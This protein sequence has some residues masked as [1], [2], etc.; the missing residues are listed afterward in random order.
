[1][2]RGPLGLFLCQCKY[3]PGI[4][5]ECGLLGSKLVDFPIE[6]NHKLPLVVGTDLD[7]LSRYRRLVGRLIYLTITCPELSYAVHILSQFMHHPKEAHM[8]E[9]RRVL[10]Y[11]KTTPGYDILLRVDS[12][13]QMHAYCDVDWGACPITRR[14]LV[15]Y[16]VTL[17]DSPISG[18]T[19]K[20]VTIF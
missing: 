9:V 15:G 13:L 6:E 18:K 4:V 16:L 19:R 3:A 8:D 12:S 11:L 7:D 20:Q 2:D 5:D 14:S 10:R 17:S 1:M